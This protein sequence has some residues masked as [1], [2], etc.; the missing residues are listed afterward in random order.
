M[1]TVFKWIGIVLGVLVGLFVLV[2]GAVYGITEARINR[3]YDIRVE[4]VP[5][6]TD[7]DA[8]AYG[9]RLMKARGCVDCHGQNLGG[10]VFLESPT[11]GRLVAT[12]LTAGRNGIGSYYTVADYVRAIRHGVGPDGKPLLFMPAHEYYFLSDADLGAMIAYLKSAPPV[13]SDLP[14][15]QVALP[16]RTL[17]L[18]TGQVALL[19]AEWVD[20]DAPRPTP[21]AP[22]VTAAYGQ[23]LAVTCIGCHGPGLSGGPIP[24]VPADWPPAS[25]LTPGGRLSQWSEDDFIRVMRTG[26][27]PDGK[28]IANRYM[29]WQALGQM[30]DDELKAL[31][32]YLQS[33]PAKPTGNR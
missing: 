21:P 11:A 26:V 28:Q 23:Y 3:T 4:E 1:K 6:P 2:V 16:I 10:R 9:E 32:L 12:N 18:L 7:A 5:I 33:L 15:S 13:D 20:H 27:T 29:P 19:P 17:Y 25:N 24:G 31:W 14:P 30:T 22:G 8:I